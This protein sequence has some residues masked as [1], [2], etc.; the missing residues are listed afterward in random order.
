MRPKDAVCWTSLSGNVD[1]NVVV[2]YGGDPSV[3]PGESGMGTIDGSAVQV[4]LK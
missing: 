2:M 1:N 4:M 3:D